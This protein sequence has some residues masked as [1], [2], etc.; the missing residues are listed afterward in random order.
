MEAV[1]EGDKSGPG[2]ALRLP[3]LPRELQAALHRFGAA[4]AEERAVEARA[5]AELVRQFALQRVVEKIRRVQQR[6]RLSHEGRRQRRMSVAERGDANARQ[7]VEVRAAIDVEQT[8]A[9]AAFEHDGKPLVVLQDVL[10]LSRLYV[11][12]H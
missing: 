6:R 9:L 2:L 12:W 10:R 5:R 1:L 3:V 4:V 7:E 11:G 8:H